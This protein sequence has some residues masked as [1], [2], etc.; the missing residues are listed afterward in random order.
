MTFG[1]FTFENIYYKIS[2]M[3]ATVL[4]RFDSFNSLNGFDIRIFLAGH[5]MLLMD[6]LFHFIDNSNKTKPASETKRKVPRRRM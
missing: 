3:G 1:S 4:L 2:I 5:P 6:I